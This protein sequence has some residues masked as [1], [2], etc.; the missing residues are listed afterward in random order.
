MIFVPILTLLFCL[1]YVALYFLLPK[2][3]GQTIPPF[4]PASWRSMAILLVL[5]LGTQ[6][7]SLLLPCQQDFG[8]GNRFLHAI[9]GGFLAFLMYFLAARDSKI[10]IAKFQFFVFGLLFV[11]SLG[12]A[13]ELFEFLIQSTTGH[14]FSPTPI[15]TWLDL[16]SNTAGLLLAAAFFVPLYGRKK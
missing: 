2:F 6:L 15:D 16:T 10:N 14:I 3:F 4:G 12:V 7:L 13:Y 8:I 5:S 9:G 11:T 1:T